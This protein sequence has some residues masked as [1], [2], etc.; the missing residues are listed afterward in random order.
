M[1]LTA[2]GGLVAGRLQIVVSAEVVPVGV[3]PHPSD[4]GLVQS[5]ALP[6]LVLS[7]VLAG[8][9]DERAALLRERRYKQLVGPV[10]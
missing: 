5:L 9:T 1:Q 8:E 7:V 6:G 10:V 2:E 4:G 3:H